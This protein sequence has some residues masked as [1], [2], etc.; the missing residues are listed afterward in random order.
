MKSLQLHKVSN[1]S[2]FQTVTFKKKIYFKEVCMQQITCENYI[3]I[4]FNNFKL[5]S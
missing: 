3:Q 2:E 1:K 5:I 4:G